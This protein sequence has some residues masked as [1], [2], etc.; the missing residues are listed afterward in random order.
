MTAQPTSS[1]LARKK[2]GKFRREFRVTGPLFLFLLPGVL[3]ML[4]FNYLPMPGVLIAFKQW[5]I[6]GS[7]VFVNF[8]N[9]A[10]V[11]FKNLFP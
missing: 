2:K 3:F 4:I 1:P 9:S 10:W 5:H 7:N 11:G 8:A 6:S